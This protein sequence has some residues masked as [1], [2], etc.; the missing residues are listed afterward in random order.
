MSAKP[1]YNHYFCQ[2]CGERKRSTLSA[3][4][5]DI[6]WDAIEA[7]GYY[8]G[9]WK[10]QT[11]PKEGTGCGKPAMLMLEAIGGNPIIYMTVDARALQWGGEIE[12]FD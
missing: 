2:E 6:R 10:D 4:D 5:V 7:A 12:V 8:C 1:K 11:V 9:Q 3:S